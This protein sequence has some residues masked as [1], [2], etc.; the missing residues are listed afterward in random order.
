M[1]EV[2]RLARH[3]PVRPIDVLFMSRDAEDGLLTVTGRI[4]TPSTP[5]RALSPASFDLTPIIIN[6]ISTPCVVRRT[7]ETDGR[8]DRRPWSR[9]CAL[10]F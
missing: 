6:C 8:G 7:P 2:R 5:T 9:G 1:G 3:G 4:R 10:A